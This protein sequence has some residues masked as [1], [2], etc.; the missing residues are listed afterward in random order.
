MKRLGGKV[1][2]VGRVQAAVLGC[3]ELDDEQSKQRR[4]NFRLRERLG[5]YRGQ[6]SSRI[7]SVDS[8][9]VPS[10]LLDDI[11]SHCIAA[12]KTNE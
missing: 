10:A 7:S 2:V 4:V 9:Q 1:P 8:R 5:C 6:E 12:S 3:A 11:T